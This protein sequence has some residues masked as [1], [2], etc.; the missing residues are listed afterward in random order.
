MD[1]IVGTVPQSA[2]GYSIVGELLWPAEF[3]WVASVFAKSNIELCPSSWH[4]QPVIWLPL[5]PQVF[6]ASSGNGVAPGS[7]TSQCFH[8]DSLRILMTR[9][10]KF[11]GY[12]GDVWGETHQGRMPSDEHFEI[13]WGRCAKGARGTEEARGRSERFFFPWCPRK[14]IKNQGTTPWGGRGL[15]YNQ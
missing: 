6:V 8:L 5:R 12:V 3:V 15:F 1:L 14:T 2:R 13:S 4:V 9:V 11:R 10:F 7:C